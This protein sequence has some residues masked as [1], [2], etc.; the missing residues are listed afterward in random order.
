MSGEERLDLSALDPARDPERWER[1]VAEALARVDAV[2]P[3]TRGALSTIAAWRRPLLIAAAV[4]L[5]LLV[6]VE[7]ALEAR[8]PR[9]EQVRRLV[10]LSVDW[11]RGAYPPSVSDF[12]R[13]L[14]P[15]EVP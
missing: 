5:A 8:E 9:V 1:V 2:L 14:A 11:G 4:T 7:L 13:A 3:H 10:S 15:G 6:P 12:L